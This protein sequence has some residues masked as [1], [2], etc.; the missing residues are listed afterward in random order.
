M[1]RRAG[2]GR[3]VVEGQKSNPQLPDPRR[4]EAVWA[5]G[6]LWLE[7]SSAVWGT[8]LP[9]YP[10]SLS[11]HLFHLLFHLFELQLLPPCLPSTCAERKGVQLCLVPLKEGQQ[12]LGRGDDLLA[13]DVRASNPI[14][15]NG[16]KGTGYC[17][18]LSDPMWNCSGNNKELDTCGTEVHIQWELG[19]HCHVDIVTVK[20]HL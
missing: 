16:P 19:G 9:S 10:L 15:W 4:C 7:G 14:L 3:D 1:G 13:S 6:R 11:F 2:E 18:I 20:Y 8:G 17:R 12:P 5:E